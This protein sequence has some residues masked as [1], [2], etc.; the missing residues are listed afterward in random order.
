MR[1]MS[2]L[3]LLLAVLALFVVSATALAGC[4]PTGPEWV[5]HGGTYTT[6]SLATLYSKA[7]ISKLASQT[8]S[9][10]A[11]LRH[12]ALT[13]LRQR[14]AAAAAAADLVTKILP[15]DTRGVPVYVEKATVSGEPAIIVIEA[16]GRPN[17]PLSTKRLWAISEQGAVLFVGNH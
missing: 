12:D 13:G 6:E 11:K 1:R 4:G 14:D 7:D 5:E 9:D 2:R 16:T 15:S 3:M 8:P 10:V 17:G